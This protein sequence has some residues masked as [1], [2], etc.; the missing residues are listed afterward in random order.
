MKTAVGALSFTVRDMDI[1]TSQKSSLEKF[2][3]YKELFCFYE[4]DTE[5]K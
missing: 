4:I 2:R 3:K 1:N 5:F